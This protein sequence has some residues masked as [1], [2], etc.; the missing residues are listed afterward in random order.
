MT[1]GEVG[2]ARLLDWTIAV[3]AAAVVAVYVFRHRSLLSDLPR[4]WEALF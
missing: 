1:P 4:L 2:R 3:S